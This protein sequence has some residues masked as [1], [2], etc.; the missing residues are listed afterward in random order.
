MNHLFLT[1]A[2]TPAL[3]GLILFSLSNSKRTFYSQHVLKCHRDQPQVF[4][5][6]HQF[7]SLIVNMS[8]WKKPNIYTCQHVYMHMAK[9]ELLE[10][11]DLNF[12]DSL[13]VKSMLNFIQY[14]AR[15]RDTNFPQKIPVVS[16]TCALSLTGADSIF[17]PK[18]CFA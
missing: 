2:E 5:L 17:W 15:I 3:S 14:C 4:I 10:L 7:F 18:I 1:S 11:H 8:A 6:N 16:Y 12:P 9:F 13:R